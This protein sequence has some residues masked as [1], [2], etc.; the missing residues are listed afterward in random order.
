M[1]YY[2]GSSIQCVRKLFRKNS[3]LP[4]DTH[5]YVC[6]SGSKKCQLFGKFCLYTKW[7]IPRINKNCMRIALTFYLRRGTVH[8]GSVAELFKCLAFNPNIFCRF[9][10]QQSACNFSCLL[11]SHVNCGQRSTTREFYFNLLSTNST[12]WS[13]ALKQFVDCC[14][15]IVWV[16]LTILWGWY[17]KG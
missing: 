15:W 5:V 6:V 1:N 4:P 16:C 2:K 10:F 8:V 13:N 3:I 9:L 12:K 14:R 11:V 7:M 17:S